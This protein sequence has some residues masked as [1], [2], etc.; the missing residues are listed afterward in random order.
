MHQSIAL[1]EFSRKMLFLELFEVISGQ[2]NPKNSFK[3][4]FLNEGLMYH[5]VGLKSVKNDLLRSNKKPN[6]I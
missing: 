2:K 4:V 6:I 3:Y 5:V 1:V